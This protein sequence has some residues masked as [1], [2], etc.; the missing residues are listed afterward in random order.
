[1]VM[2]ANPTY[3]QIGIVTVIK[4]GIASCWRIYAASYNYSPTPCP[5]SS[6]FVL[7]LLPTKHTGKIEAVVFCIL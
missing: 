5:L 4:D 2:K 6:S 7:V 1:M 3:T